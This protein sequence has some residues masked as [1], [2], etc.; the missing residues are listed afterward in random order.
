MN[1]RICNHCYIMGRPL[2]LKPG[3]IPCRRCQGTRRLCGELCSN[4]YDGTE[5]CPI[6]EGSGY[7]IE[8]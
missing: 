6:C 7:I 4:C 1:E 2:G 5:P 8:S 3:R